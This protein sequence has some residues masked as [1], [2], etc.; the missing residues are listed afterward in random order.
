[1]YIDELLLKM[2]IKCNQH[3]IIP[4]N[5]YRLVQIQVVH[6]QHVPLKN[7]SMLM[8]FV[9]FSSQCTAPVPNYISLSLSVFGFFFLLSHFSWRKNF[10]LYKNE[11]KKTITTGIT[12]FLSSFF[13]HLSIKLFV[14]TGNYQNFY[15]RNGLWTVCAGSNAIFFS[16]YASVHSIVSTISINFFH[17]S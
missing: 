8:T 9:F 11:T 17:Q 15:M 10:F 14:S 1:M 16:L 12:L 2:F 4:N 6:H 3:Q 13:C 5:N 7:D